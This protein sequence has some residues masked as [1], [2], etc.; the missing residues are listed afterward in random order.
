MPNKPKLS[1]ITIN[2][3]NASGL[4]KTIA[5]VSMQTFSEYEFIIIDGGSID[6]SL[7]I[8]ESNHGKIAYWLSEPDNGIYHAMN[9]GIRQAKGEYCLF[10]NSGDW[11]DSPTILEELFKLPPKADIVAGD[12][13]FYDTDLQQIKWLVP[14]PDELTAKTLFNGTLPHQATLIKRELFERIGLY[15]ESLKIA[16]DWLFWVEALLEKGCSYQH[17]HG[18]VSYFSMDGISCNPATNNLPK[19]EQLTILQQKYPRFIKDYQLLSALENEKSN[20]EGSKEFAVYQFLQKL[21]VIAVGIFMYR[22]F[23]FFG[24]I[25]STN[26]Y[27]KKP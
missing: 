22:V 4:A 6:Q 11:L 21:G 27:R 10:L 8:I 26:N 13:Y 3:N 12:V 15:N 23:Q 14:S 9:K 2:L 16:S 7:A 1:I 18:V 24:R 5:S 19:R 25:I 20:W 17:F